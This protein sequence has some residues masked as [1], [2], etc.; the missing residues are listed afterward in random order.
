[1]ATLTIRNLDDDLKKR[2]R[3]EAAAR[4]H[5]MEEEAR[6]I[7]RRS[8]AGTVAPDG[9]GTR[10]HERFAKIGGVTLEAPRRQS[11]PRGARFEK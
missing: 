1:M 4:G 6:E 10:I 5:S 3:L 8:L 9:L 11:R 7:L 2:L